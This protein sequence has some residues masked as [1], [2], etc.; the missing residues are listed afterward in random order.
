[1]FV[2]DIRSGE[3]KKWK[4][5]VRSLRWAESV[6]ILNTVIR[7]APGRKGHILTKTLG[8]QGKEE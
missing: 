5:G 7:K 8:R 3:Y 1:M 4:R 6:E 2:G